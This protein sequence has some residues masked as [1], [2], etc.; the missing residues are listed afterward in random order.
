[1][2][3]QDAV[4]AVT[5]G[6]WDMQQSLNLVWEYLLPA[7]G[8]A[9]LPTNDE[10]YTALTQKLA[11]LRLPP[12]EGQPL[13]PT[14]A[15]VS[16]KTYSIAENKDGIKTIRFDF[17]AGET[18]ITISNDAG[19]QRI[20]CGYGQWLRGVASLERATGASVAETRLPDPWKVGA[21]GAWTDDQ[22]YTARLWWYQTPVAR[23]LTCR[24]VDDRLTVEQQTNVGFGPSGTLLKG[25]V[26]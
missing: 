26:A 14:G 23:T 9:P 5:A 22:T 1:M 2:P 18:R 10:V 15:C 17:G 11:S 3:E 7:M 24:F 8:P 4:L 12:L 20:A 13:T 21:S 19:Q 16:G 25:Q 6:L